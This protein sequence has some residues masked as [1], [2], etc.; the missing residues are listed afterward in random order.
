MV[1]SILSFVV[2]IALFLLLVWLTRRLWR[3]R[4][5]GLRWLG[6]IVFGLLTAVVGLVTVVALVGAAR[7][8]LPQSNPVPEVTVAGTPE[9]IERGERLVNICAGCHST[10][11]APP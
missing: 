3:V 10:A 5:P 8:N 1:A 2:V 7:L 4:N 11:M 9:Q 6:V